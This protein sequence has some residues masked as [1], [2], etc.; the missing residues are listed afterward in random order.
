MTHTTD[1][2]TKAQFAAVRRLQPIRRLLE[3]MG[4]PCPT[5]TN[6]YTDNAAVSAIVDAN[7]MTPRCQHIDIPIAYLHQEHKKSFHNILLRTNQMIA[8][9]GTK[10]LV[11]IL[12][13]R[14][15]YWLMGQS[16]LPQRGTLHYT[17]LQMDL[18]EQYFLDFETIIAKR[19]S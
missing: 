19:K 3:S 9:L 10:P 13:R 6:V 18:Y 5:P 15:K 17:L 16:F 12:H 2:E 4:Y 7:R 1:S 8:D 14:F 11:T